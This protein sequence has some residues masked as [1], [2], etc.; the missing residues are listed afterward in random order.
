MF[1][2]FYCILKKIK[3]QIDRNDLPLSFPQIMVLKIINDHWQIS[4]SQIAKDLNITKAS[5]SAMIQKLKKLELITTKIDSNDKRINRISLSTKW[6]KILNN[7]RKK[8]INSSQKLFQKLNTQEQ[9][10]LL[11]LLTKLCN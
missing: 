11:K 4:S 6:K 7:T 9:K 10:T 5:M 8:V 3:E 1:D 2:H